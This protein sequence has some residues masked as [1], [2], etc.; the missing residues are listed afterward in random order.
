M[1][2]E[3]RAPTTD[4]DLSVPLVP[5]LRPPFLVNLTAA[6]RL[7][8]LGGWALATETDSRVEMIR[9]QIMVLQD[10]RLLRGKFGLDLVI[11]VLLVGTEAQRNWSVRESSANHIR[12]EKLWGKNLQAWPGRSCW[13]E[14]RITH[15]RR[16]WFAVEGARNHGEK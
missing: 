10:I 1:P 4:A 9:F 15:S 2:T 16:A 12:L 5:W 8:G 13:L 11:R 3:R 7:C 14:Q 6:G